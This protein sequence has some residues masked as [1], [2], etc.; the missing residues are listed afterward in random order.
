M[1]D[2][3][4]I[5]EKEYKEHLKEAGIKKEQIE[6]IWNRVL[7]GRKQ[8]EYKENKKRKWKKEKT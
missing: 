4:E 6:E 8:E 5:P 1:V 2:I 3:K 7:I